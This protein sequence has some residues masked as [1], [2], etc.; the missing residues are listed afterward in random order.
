MMKEI[1]INYHITEKCNFICKHCFAEYGM[2]GKYKNEL[3]HDVGQVRAMLYDVYK[4]YSQKGYKNIRINFAGGEPLIIKNFPQIIKMAY[5]IGYKV[6]I[7]TNGSALSKKF[8]K[9]NAIFLSV[10]GLSIDSFNTETNTLIGRVTRAGRGNI[11]ADIT[12]KIELLRKIN[13]NILIK[14]NTVVSKLNYNELMFS[15]INSICPDKWKIFEV[16]PNTKNEGHVT[17]EQFKLFVSNHKQKVNAPM[18]VEEKDD[19]LDSYIMID[20]MG[21]FYQRQSVFS[22]N[23]FSSPIIQFGTEQAQRQITFDRNK[24]NQRYIPLV[25]AA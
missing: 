3:H 10:F 7:I 8:I 19:L 12:Q 20:P 13:P 2:E 6:S 9:A 22:S 11:K 25:N 17:N 1:V 23:I 5:Q 21:R 16:L 18:F 15:E 14:V 4:Y 24:F